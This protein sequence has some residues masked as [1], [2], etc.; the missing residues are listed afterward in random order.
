MA[1]TI[2]AVVG[3]GIFLAILDILHGLTTAGFYGYRFIAHSFY[4]CPRELDITVCQNKIYIYEQR[5]TLRTYIG[6]GEG[7][8][9]PVFDIIYII[10][11][12]KHMPWLTWLWLFKSF[13][14]MGINVFYIS[15]W[16]VRSGSFDHITYERQEYEELFLLVGAGLTV[17]QLVIMVLYCI[18]GG[19]FTYK[20]AEE[21]TRSRRS[22]HRSPR[23]RKALVL[24]ATA[25][26]IDVYD[27]EDEGGSVVRATIDNHFV[28]HGLSD[29]THK[30]PLPGSNGSIDQVGRSDT[31]R[32]PTQV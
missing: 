21:R 3:F 29:S 13:G 20:V 8:I 6:L 12:V 5:Y 32:Q 30:L 14:V 24:A 1:C 23:M 18:I 11:L 25:P 22:L 7:V 2:K 28:N 26:P 19:V 10:A 4:L 17:A 31:V 27:D 15:R 9:T 16:M